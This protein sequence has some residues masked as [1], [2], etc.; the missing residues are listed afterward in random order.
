MT[1]LAWLIPLAL[2]LG[3]AGLAAATAFSYIC[4][5]LAGLPTPLAALLVIG[6]T[7]GI[8]FVILRLWAFSIA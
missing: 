8:N 1:G 7:S 5:R 6:L 4:Y 2:C 3:L